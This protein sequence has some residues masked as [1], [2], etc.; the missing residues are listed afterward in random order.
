[1]SNLRIFKGTEVDILA[2]G[3]L[4]Y[5]DPV[6]SSFDYVVAAI[7]SKFNMTEAE[8]TKRVM[9]ALKNKHVTFLGHPTG[10]LLLSRDGYPVNMVEV[11]NA[12]SDYGKG[13]EINSH[14]F[15]LDLDWRLVKHAKA[16]K[17][18]IYINPDA[19][20]TDGL[21]DVFYG[22]GIARKGWLEVNDVVNAWSR[23]KVEAFLSK[24]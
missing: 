18:P 23:R 20:N 1:M 11:I 22:V 6:L 16:K 19:H 17:V 8:A 7:H 2:D 21:L 14:P 12:A 5:S 9:K 13:I 3:S 24:S 10:R 4:D 15:R